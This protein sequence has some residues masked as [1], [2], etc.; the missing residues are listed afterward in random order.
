VDPPARRRRPGRLRG[1]AC[2][3]HD[4]AHRRSTP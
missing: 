2:G 3:L 4:R 1:D